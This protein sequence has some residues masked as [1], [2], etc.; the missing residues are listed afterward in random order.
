MDFRRER[1]LNYHVRQRPEDNKVKELQINA[2]GE[3]TNEQKTYIENKNKENQTDETWI[4][5]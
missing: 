1:R 3:Y 4:K 2:Q 5:P